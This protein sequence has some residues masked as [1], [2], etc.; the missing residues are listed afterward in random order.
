M[1]DFLQRLRAANGARQVEWDGSGEL[2]I[3]FRCNELAGEAG[4]ACNILKKLDRANYGLRGCRANINALAEEFADVVIC[5]DLLAMNYQHAFEGCGEQQPTHDFA[6]KGWEEHSVNED[7]D[8]SLAGARLALRVGSLCGAVICNA[9]S[10]EILDE[11]CEVVFHVK[12]TADWLKLDLERAVTT[13][14]NMTSAKHGF[15]T[16]LK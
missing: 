5:C 15:A 8:L 12:R 1:G 9:P 13:K 6:L 3:V 2:S 11:I 14:F 10:A 16:R 7:V 4:E